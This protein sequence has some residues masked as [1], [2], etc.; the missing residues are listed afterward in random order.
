MKISSQLYAVVSLLAATTTTVYAFLPPQ[1]LHASI[2]SSSSSSALSA[3]RVVWL[4]GHEDLR[5]RD[6]G[7]F[8]D[9][10]NTNDDIV[11][12]FILDHELHLSCKSS[13]AIE[14]LHSI[15]RHLN[16]SWRI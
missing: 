5:L 14:R 10:F 1:Q 6:H 4:T 9:A 8:A 16:Q 13:S 2:S 15:I 3:T 7:G 11:P 12:V